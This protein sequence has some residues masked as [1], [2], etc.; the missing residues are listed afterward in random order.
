MTQHFD[1]LVRG[2]TVFDGTGAPGRLADVGVLGDRIAAIGDLAG[3]TADTVVE[4]AGRAVAPGFIDVHT[5]DD[6]ALLSNPDMAMK[7]SQGVTT[8]VVGNC[9]VSL[10]PLAIDR[11]PPPPLDLL[12]AEEWY[13]YPRMA[14]YMAAVDAAPAAVNAACLVGHATLRVGAMD[15]LLR[16]AT[17]AEINNMKERLAE[18][19]A[20]GAIGMSTGL[21]YRPANAAPTEEIIALAELLE[22]A[23]A[24]YTT[25]MRDEGEGVMDSLHESFRIGREAGVRAI[26]SHHKVIGTPNFGR[27]EETLALIEHTRTRQD[28]GL[29]CYPYVAASTVLDSSRLERCSR[30]MVT[31]SVKHPEVSGRDLS[32]IAAEWG[33]SQLEAVDRLNPAG[34]IYFM[35]D[36]ADVRRILSYPH[37]IVASDGLP[38]DSH[39]H[40]RLWGTFPR[41]LGHYSRDVGLFPLEE[42]VRRMTGLP[43]ERFGLTG[44]GRLAVGAHADITVFDPATVIDSASFEKPATPA[45]GIDRVI[46]N[47]RAVWADGAPTGAHPGRLLRRQDLQAA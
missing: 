27:S 31:W 30:V 40:P 15:D 3:A 43:A 45:A 8:V 9:G 13:R 41:V 44:R 24:I 36:E 6:R 10:S 46:V 39:P 37:T 12:G 32:D 16:P 47:G 35:M 4:A 42:A 22:P 1:L 7:T 29:D 38:H 11:R 34:A 23:G 28:I 20:A 26:I 21:F 33:I 2:G 5:H 18:G 25:H 17:P 19:L 14:D